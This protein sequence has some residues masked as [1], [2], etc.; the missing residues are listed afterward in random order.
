MSGEVKIELGPGEYPWEDYLHVD[1]R[2]GLPCQEVQADLLSLP[3]KNNCADE[4]FSVQVLEHI[5]WKQVR[6]MLAES[7]RIL[8]IGGMFRCCTI[9]IV[10]LSKMVLNKEQPITTLLNWIYGGGTYEENWHKGAFTG[11]YMRELLEELNYSIETLTA[12]DQVW[13]EAR[14]Q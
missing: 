1:V 4:V 5:D 3:F 2:H 8:K 9:D 14:K 7:H 11:D 10:G 13:V 12:S 6:P